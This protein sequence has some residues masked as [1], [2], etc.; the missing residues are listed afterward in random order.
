[1]SKLEDEDEEEPLL[2]KR[3]WLDE[4]E[5]QP[6]GGYPG[7]MVFGNQIWLGCRTSFFACLLASAIWIPAT[8]PYVDQGLA[9]Y[10]PLSVL[11]IFFTMQPVFGSI[12]GSATA[13]ITGTF[14][15]VFNIFMLRGFFPDGVTPGDGF[16]SPASIAGWLDLAIFNFVMCSIDARPGF[17]MF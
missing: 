6:V 4:Y 13:A 16:F 1:M 14:W 11:M 2:P 10:V 7:N 15:A 12:V 5:D 9:K 17:K 8:K 3:P